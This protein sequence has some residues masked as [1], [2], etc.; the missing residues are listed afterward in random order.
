[1]IFCYRYSFD[2]F[3]KL[4]CRRNTQR[5]ACLSLIRTIVNQARFLDLLLSNLDEYF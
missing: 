1:M 3:G 2:H 4:S 5:K